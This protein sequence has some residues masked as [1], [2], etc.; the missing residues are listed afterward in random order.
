MIER[1]D[2]L[3]LAGLALAATS[4]PAYSV[5]NAEPVRAGSGSRVVIVGAGMA[6]LVAAR[7]LTR[8][9]HDVVVIEGSRRVGGRIWTSHEW[10][11]VPIDLGASWIHGV[12]G[13]PIT[14][15]ARE[16]GA[17]LATTS[18]DSSVAYGATGTQLTPAQERRVA[19]MGRRVAK[20]LRAAQKS[21]RDQSVESAVRS[22]LGWSSL[23]AADRV[24]ARFILTSTIEAEYS[25]AAD[26][27]SAY[28]FDSVGEYAGEDAIFLDGYSVVID[29]LARGTRVV[30]GQRVT[31]IAAD[32]GGV[33]VTTT[34]G[35]YR[36]DRVIVTVP[37][38][39][40]QADVIRFS[41]TLPPVKRQAIAALGMGVL[42]KVFLRFPEVFW[43]PSKDWIEY[44][45]DGESQWAEWVSFA[46]PTGQ[47]ILLGFTAADFARRMELRSDDQI[48]AS[49]M[50]TLRTI[51]GP[52]VP[53]PVG[54]QI[55]RWAADRF[56]YGSYSFNAL[57]SHPRMR[58]DLAAPVDDRIFFAGEATEHEYFG[59]VHGAYL[60]GRRAAAQVT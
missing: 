22:G 32:A 48:V 51:Y 6:G 56:S 24:L 60:S 28:W 25:G 35:T 1:R 26:A 46:R 5:S 21:G 49:A 11:D 58:D 54:R 17:R 30:T 59:T 27:T 45:P 55:T 9:G 41:P 10:P 12:K 8:R 15:L 7:E 38:G 43:D 53:D 29:E 2:L 37:L 13:N 34:K 50:V 47:P 4:I 33:R 31:E 3:R 18:Y 36:G 52:G 23:S 42:D 14:A 16:A 19:A 39:V 57:G 44:I 40:L 20:A